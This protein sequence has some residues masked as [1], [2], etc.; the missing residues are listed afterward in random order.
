MVYIIMMMITSHHGHGSDLLPRKGM[1]AW[2]YERV[3][4]CEYVID[5]I[6]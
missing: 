3:E 1:A 4:E 6:K 5:A 2:H